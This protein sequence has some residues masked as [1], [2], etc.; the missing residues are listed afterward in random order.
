MTTSAVAMP[1]PVV[2]TTYGR[3]RGASHPSG[4]MFRGIPYAAPPTGE[5][6]FR[7]PSPPQPWA[8]IRDC[9]RDGPACPQPA[10]STI[11]AVQRLVRLP[12]SQDEDCLHLN[13]WTPVLGDEPRPV[14]VWIHGG[15]FR[16][17]SGSNWPAQ[18]GTFSRDGVLLV[19]INYRLHA[20]GHLYLDELFENAAGSGNA[21][22]LDQ[23]AALGWIHDNIAAFGG[24]PDNVTVFGSSAGASSIATLMGVPDARGLFR[25]AITM[26]AAGPCTTDPATATKVS[27]AFLAAVGVR[28]GDSAALASIPVERVVAAVSRPL[29]WPRPATDRALL[30]FLPVCDG[31]ILSDTPWRTLE[32]NGSPNVDL[33]VGTTAEEW[34]IVHFGA[35]GQFPPPDIGAI[36]HLAGAASEAQFLDVYRRRNAEGID[37]SYAA[38]DTDLLFTIPA[39]RLAE[40]HLRNTSR[41]WMYRFCWP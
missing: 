12:V 35:P 8:T 18:T 3:V 40:A 41:V 9:S 37:D 6:R 14:M 31:R 25:R 22:L 28:P 30:D 23:L 27:E 24:D 5:L 39:V 36:S 38:V 2:D 21:G 11:P 26:S 7:P 13:V 10:P 1:E 32:Q 29:I 15:A 33:L 19:T 4:Y 17:G 20:F 34:R 16:T